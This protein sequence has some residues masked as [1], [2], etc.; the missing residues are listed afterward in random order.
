MTTSA[1]QTRFELSFDQ[2]CPLPTQNSHFDFF[3]SAAGGLVFLT[4]ALIILL[5][6][7]FTYVVPLLVW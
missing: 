2:G 3:Q 1:A 4:A 7:A 6:F 5:F